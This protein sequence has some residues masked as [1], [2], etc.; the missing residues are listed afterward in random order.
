MFEEIITKDEVKFN[1]LERKVFKFV[2]FFRC[3]IIKLLL[4]SYD[5]KLMNTRDPKKYRHK[6][7]RT[8]HVNTVMGEVKFRRTMYEIFT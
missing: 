3:L 2:C 6:G 7:L 1:E 8:T 4:E 5:K